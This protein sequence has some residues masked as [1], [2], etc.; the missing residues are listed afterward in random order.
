[1]KDKNGKEELRMWPT[2][3]AGQCGMSAKT[4]GRDV[5]KS[6]FLGTQVA[7]EEGLIDPETGCLWRSQ[8]KRAE[9]K[10]EESEEN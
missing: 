6:G 8:R 2:P 4:S 9:P 10:P 1:M 3:R 5:T 7:L